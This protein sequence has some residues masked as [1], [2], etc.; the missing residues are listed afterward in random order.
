MPENRLLAL[1]ATLLEKL[2]IGTSINV[3]ELAVKDDTY[4]SSVVTATTGSVPAGAQLIIA[5]FSSDFVGTFNG[6]SRTAGSSL[7]I[8]ASLGGKL[9]AVSYTMSAGNITL[10][11][12]SQ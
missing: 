1:I 9:P 2:S 12:V 3:S 11:I 8:G 7:S 5:Y 4:A 10:D 6:V